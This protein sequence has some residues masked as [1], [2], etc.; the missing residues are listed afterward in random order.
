M[1]LAGRTIPCKHIQHKNRALNPLKSEL[2]SMFSLS[3]R[4]VGIRENL[5]VASFC[6]KIR[7]CIN[8]DIESVP[9]I[10]LL[11]DSVNISC[12]GLNDHLG[13]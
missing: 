11:T 10:W 9:R 3:I 7:D 6:S 8:V 12:F 5:V 13:N 4:N 2:L 1:Q